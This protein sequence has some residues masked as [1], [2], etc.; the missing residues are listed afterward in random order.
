MS[1][2]GHWYAKMYGK[3][4]IVPTNLIYITSDRKSLGRMHI[5]LADQGP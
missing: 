5:L 2:I 1:D 3:S 4:R